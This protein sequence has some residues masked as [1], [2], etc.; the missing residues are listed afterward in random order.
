PELPGRQPAE[1][2]Q[3]KADTGSVD[4]RG[5][6]LAIRVV[7]GLFGLIFF[8]TFNNF[9]A[10]V[11]MSLLDAYGLLLVS[12]EVWGTLWGLLILGFIVGGLIVARRGLGP[13]PLRTLFLSNIAM[14]SICCVFALRSSIVLLAA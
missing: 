1:A 10:G 3:V 9:L 14:W 4:I 13:N 6:I 12:V 8:N 7:P 2:A 11:F 5:T